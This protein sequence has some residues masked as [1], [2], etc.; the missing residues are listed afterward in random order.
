[1]R[2]WSPNMSKF[3]QHNATTWSS[4]RSIDRRTLMGQA[5][6]AIGLLATFGGVSTA[7]GQEPGTAVATPESELKMDIV[8]LK[9]QVE[10][11]VIVPGDN[12]YDA[13]RIGWNRIAEHRPDAIVMATTAED[14]VAGVRLATDAGLPIA[15]QATGHGPAI[16]ADGGVLINTRQMTECAIDSTTNTA[17]F[18]PG[19]TWNPVVDAAAEHG[20]AP[21]VGTCTTVGATGYLTGGGLPALGRTY[22]F[23]VD[24]VRALNLVTAD[25]KLRRVSPE[26]E[27]DL[28]WAV[29]GGKGNF[30]I[31]T[32]VETGLVS[33]STIYG[34]GLFFPGESAANVMRVWLEWTDSQPETMSSSVALARFPDVPVLPDPLRG[35]TL[36]HVRIAFA[37]TASEGERLVQ[38]L[39]ALGTTMDTVDEMPYSQIGDIY[40]NPT[41]PAPVRDGGLLLQSLDNGAIDTIV[42]LAGPEVSLPPGSIELRHLGGAIARPPEIPSPIGTRNAAFNLMAGMLALPEQR[43]LVDTT[44]Q[45]LLEALAPWSTGSISPN[46]L[47]SLDTE[48]ERVRR[49]YTDEDYK[50]LTGIK[51]AYDPGNLFRFN[52]NIPPAAHGTRWA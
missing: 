35:A 48:P 51:A 47:G 22:G 28:F 20:L 32:E 13:E 29:R 38:A 44:L 41:Q 8:D 17:T 25:G 12:A 18:G 43:E 19:V 10:G 33:L 52:H 50:M 1:M 40:L 16:M 34:G 23:A 46:F 14:V 45:Q 15:V 2:E 39:R 6:S 30:G 27:P 37:G 5:S 4:S 36:V 24:H 42:E 11:T 21:L 49:A 3:K 26:E 9:S 7:S 31:V